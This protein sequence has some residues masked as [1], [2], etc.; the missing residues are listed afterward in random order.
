MYVMTSVLVDLLRTEPFL[1]ETSSTRTGLQVRFIQDLSPETQ[2]VLR[3]L[4]KQS[5]HHRVR[6]RAHCIL[7]SFQG[8][9]TNDLMKIFDVDRLTIYHWFNAWETRRLA[10]LYD[11]KGRGRPQKLTPEEQEKVQQYIEQHPK[12]IKKVVHLLEQ[13]TAK[14]VSTKTINRLVKKSAMSGNGSRNRQRNIQSRNS[15]SGVKP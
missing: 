3:R 10:G 1:D 6:Q 9:T 15:M 8:M 7:L 12:D 2:H 4:Y 5:Q 14:R 11:H 13:E